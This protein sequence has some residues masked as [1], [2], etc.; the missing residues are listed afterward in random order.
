[1]IRSISKISVY[2][3]NQEDAEKFWVEKLGF[4]IR[5]KQQMGPA[6][7]LEVAPVGAQTTFVLYNKELM[8]K[9]NPNMDLGHP[10]VILTTTNLDES[11][12]KMKENGVDLDDVMNMPYGRMFIF[13]DQ[14]GNRYLLREDK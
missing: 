2:V 11:Y 13:R 1:M 5:L 7:W 4:E 3:K 14:D 9:Q 12:L 10:N 6:L 8:S